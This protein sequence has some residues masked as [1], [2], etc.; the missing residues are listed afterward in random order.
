MALTWIKGGAHRWKVFVSNR[1]AF[2]QDIL[3]AHC[4]RY[5]ESQSNPADIATRGLQ[6]SAF[7]KNTM[8]LKGPKLLIYFQ[9]FQNLKEP[10]FE[11]LAEVK[12]EHKVVFVATALQINR[13]YL[14]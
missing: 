6:P 11:N 14:L 3:P 8:W 13:T 5:V 1:V 9:N 2:I 12:E 4:W 7:L 10:S